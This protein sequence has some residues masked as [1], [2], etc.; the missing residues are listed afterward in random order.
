MVGCWAVA[1]GGARNAGAAGCGPPPE[2]AR[3]AGR[4][5]LR[6][7]GRWKKGSKGVFCW[8][9]PA[10]SL[11]AVGAESRRR[12][13]CGDDPQSRSRRARTPACTPAGGRARW[14]GAEFARAI[15]EG[16]ARGRHPPLG[17][18]RPPARG[19]ARRA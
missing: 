15:F 10:P 3:S 8:A 17:L 16:A 12:P 19:R 1:R 2:C 13:T 5:R 11:L 14:A 9:V 4:G 6:R 7:G 18:L